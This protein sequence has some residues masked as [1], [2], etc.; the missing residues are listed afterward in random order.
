LRLSVIGPVMPYISLTHYILLPFQASQTSQNSFH[1]SFFTSILKPCLASLPSYLNLYIP[2]HLLLL[3]LLLLLLLLLLILLVYYTGF[4]LLISECYTNRTP[5]ERKTNKFPGV[6]W[7]LAGTRRSWYVRCCQCQARWTAAG[8]P[9][10]T[11]SPR[12]HEVHSRVPRGQLYGFCCR[13]SPE[14]FWNEHNNSLRTIVLVFL[15]VLCTLPV[16]VVLLL[17]VVFYTV[18]CEL[19]LRQAS[20][21]GASYV[22]TPK[23]PSRKPTDI[24]KDT[25]HSQG[26]TSRKIIF[27]SV[28]R[29]CLCSSR[30]TLE[31]TRRIP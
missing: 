18:L 20:G 10:A 28:F 15:T 24:N 26:R 22:Y 1:A 21:L 12:S 11:C 17:S 13:R 30:T 29:L 25:C 7:V 4:L 14:T 2:P 23:L 6:P 3:R 8:L 9:L 27:V 19:R 5:S 16:Y 31:A